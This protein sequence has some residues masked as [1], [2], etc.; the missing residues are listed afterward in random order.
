MINARL[1][2]AGRR[3]GSPVGLDLS[4]GYLQSGGE[5]TTINI[6]TRSSGLARAGTENLADV[7]TLYQD[8][9]ELYVVIQ[10][11]SQIVFDLCSRSKCSS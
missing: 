11:R 8:R 1:L 7:C 2:I 6:K 10:N 4:S 9:R 5:I 3:G